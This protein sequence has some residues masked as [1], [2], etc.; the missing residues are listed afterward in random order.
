VDFQGGKKMKKYLIPLFMVFV[1]LGSAFALAEETVPTEEVVEEFD[2]EDR[3]EP[4]LRT[5][6]LHL[7]EDVISIIMDKFGLD[8]NDSIGDLLESISTQEEENKENLRERLGVETDE[9]IRGAIHDKKVEIMRE[10]LELGAE[11][12][13]EEVIA[14]AY[15]ERR[16][17]IYDI[18]GLDSEVSDEEYK[19]AREEYKEDHKL[20]QKTIRHRTGPFRNLF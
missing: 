1:V 19:I 4:K 17:Q 8:E 3:P 14:A 7:V 12:T 11:F 15:D 5:K 10:E 13:D 9:E 2:F 16:A 20:V 18:L 6:T